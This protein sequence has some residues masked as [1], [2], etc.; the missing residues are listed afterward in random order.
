MNI[1]A[2]KQKSIS[3]KLTWWFLS[4]ESEKGWISYAN[5][6]FPAGRVRVPFTRPQTRSCDIHQAR[7]GTV[8][9]CRHGWHPDASA[10]SVRVVTLL[11]AEL[12]LGFKFFLVQRVALQQTLLKGAIT[13]VSD[14]AVT[15]PRVYTFPFTSSVLLLTSSAGLFEEKDIGNNVGSSLAR[16]HFSDYMCGKLAVR[17]TN[18]CVNTSPATCVFLRLW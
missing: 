14:W 4:F 16:N 9:W 12:S 11:R 8:E 7:W 2:R 3:L 10:A 15:R 18:L 5:L 17:W 13:S 6:S 1:I